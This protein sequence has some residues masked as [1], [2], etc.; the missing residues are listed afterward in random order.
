[1]KMSPDE[2][3]R[4]AKVVARSSDAEDRRLGALLMRIAFEDGGVDATIHL[5]VNSYLKEGRT[6]GKMSASVKA[7]VLKSLTVYALRDSHPEAMNVLGQI[8]QLQGRD[9]DALDLFISAM[10]RIKKI[11]DGEIDEAPNAP[12][13]FST[14]DVDAVLPVWII[15]GNEHL[16]RR[17]RAAAAE[18]YEEGA[19]RADDPY[20]YICAARVLR[21]TEGI[22][23]PKWV[24]YV[25]KAA[26]SGHPAAAMMLGDF[27]EAGRTAKKPI[28]GEDRKAAG[29][30]MPPLVRQFLKL[31]QVNEVWGVD[32]KYKHLDPYY[33]KPKVRDS[34]AECWFLIAANY[35]VR[36]AFVAMAKIRA[37][38]E[39][40]DS[41]DNLLNWAMYSEPGRYGGDSIYAG[42]HKDDDEAI[43][44]AVELLERYRSKG[45]I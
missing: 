7:K 5:A 10:S 33:M 2:M 12:N 23:S 1:M 39:R 26:A 13:L 28:V 21:T 9:N 16:K 45:Y 8:Y 35:G 31:I 25:T 22:Y 3:A 34:L 37:R 6:W 41:V 15:L 20:A 17:N 18:A 24:H 14:Q 38:Q 44:Q 36:R 11:D 4:V 27:Y 42:K 30:S 40:W 43:S 32:Y 19:I 29:E